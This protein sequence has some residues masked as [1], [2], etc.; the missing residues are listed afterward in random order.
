MKYLSYHLPRNA[1]WM[2]LCKDKDIK[3]EILSLPEHC[4][5]SQPSNLKQSWRGKTKTQ[6]IIQVSTWVLRLSGGSWAQWAEL[7][8]GQWGQVSARRLNTARNSLQRPRTTGGQRCIKRVFF[9]LFSR[10]SLFLNQDSNM[11]P[12][13]WKHRFLTI[14]P[15]GDF[16]VILIS[17]TFLILFR[18]SPLPFI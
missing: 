5:P 18:T 8:R 2:I 1:L 16:L 14:R 9:F 7:G 10:G 6:S 13:Q 11:C 3:K 12:M 4:P 17:I 15:P